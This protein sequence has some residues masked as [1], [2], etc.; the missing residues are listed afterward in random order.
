MSKKFFNVRV[1]GLLINARNEVLISDEQEY[2]FRFTK[3]PGGGLE[4]GEGLI[5]GLKREFVE[6]CN[7]EVEVISHFYTTDFFVKSAFNDS[8]IISVYYLVKAVS[9]LRFTTKTVLF[10]FDGEGD[11]L[12]SFRWVKLSNL[13]VD[14]FT[15]PTDQYVA[16]LLIKSI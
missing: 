11:V 15:F 12:Q 6:E 13:T 14:E 3:F 1:Y 2:G 16:D 4:Y 5:E 10:D 7:T 9:D 8:Q